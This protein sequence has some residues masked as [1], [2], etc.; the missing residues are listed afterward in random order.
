MAMAI[1]LSEKESKEHSGKV[2]QEEEDLA[3]AIEESMRHVSSYGAP[4]SSPGAGPSTFTETT[5]PLSFPSP[6]PAPEPPISQP[7][8]A[9]SHTRPVSAPLP[10]SKVSSPLTYPAH[11]SIDDDAAYAARVADEEEEVAAAG[12]SNPKPRPVV[13]PSPKPETIPPAPAPSTASKKR[14]EAQQPK[15]SV[16]NSDSEPP[17]PLYHHVISAQT[18]AKTSPKLSTNNPSLG[19]SSSASAVMPSSSRLSPIP[20][21]ADKPHGG[22]SQSLDAVPTSPSNTGPTPPV[23]ANMS[24]L[25]TVEESHDAPP[26]QSPS[27][28][29]GLV[30]QNSFIDQQLLYGVSLG[31]NPP[32][33]SSIKTTLKGGVPNVIAL[34]TGKYVPFH[35][36]APD[37]RHL[38]KMM[39]RLSGSR[40]EASVETLASSKQELKLR[41]V[42]QFVKVNS[43]SQDW[44]TVIYMTV[45]LPPPT[46]APH[47]YTNG[48]VNTLPFSYTLTTPPTLHDGPDAPLSKWYTIPATP[49]TPHPTLPISFPNMA[50]YLASAVEDSRRMAYDNSSGMKRLSKTLDM[51]YPAQV[52]LGME[53][54]EPERPDGGFVNMFKN[55]FGRGRRDPRRNDDNYADLVTPFVPEWG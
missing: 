35:I 12:P 33:I 39:A 15:F 46:T 45:D 5:S 17:P 20:G 36:Q 6:L 11:P 13:L 54:D 31:F 14:L 23:S 24:P 10:A 38:L 55:V 9:S 43:A 26:A 30:A 32:Q 16:V 37:W 29:T 42:V 2:S 41:T 44:R 27:S 21:P 18:S 28:S 19:R 50:M 3:K 52:E 48:D 8:F 53:D 51:L 4:L 25:P 34:H 47:K 7:T 1:A 49:S 40:I 22:R